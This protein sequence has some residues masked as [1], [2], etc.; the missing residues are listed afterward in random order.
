MYNKSAMINTRLIKADLMLH[1]LGVPL[2]NHMKVRFK[3]INKILIDIL[4][5]QSNNSMHKEE[6]DYK[7][8]ISR[9]ISFEK[10]FTKIIRKLKDIHLELGIL[11][12]E[13]MKVYGIP[14][15]FTMIRA[16][17]NTTSFLF[18]I[19][20]ISKDE[21]LMMPDKILFL[22]NFIIWLTV[23]IYK[24]IFINYICVG[25]IN[26]W[27]ETGSTIHKLECNSKDLNFQREIQKFSIQ[28]LQNPLKFSPGGFFDLGYYFLRDFFGSVSTQIFLL[29][30]T[31]PIHSS[32]AK[33]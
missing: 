10:D 15:V 9:K 7:W 22:S 13:L 28:M 17:T 6:T 30:Q 26:E 20:V 14:I 31:Y 25:T 32:A 11:C 21:K 3:N 23:F 18:L 8:A 2:I 27:Q 5:L 29:I 19:F 1:T 12:R 16:F 4:Q 33:Q 24:V